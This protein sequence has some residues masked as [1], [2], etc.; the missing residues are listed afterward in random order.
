MTVQRTHR[1]R[2]L[3]L[4]AKGMVDQAQE[5]I[6]VDRLTRIGYFARGLIYGLMGFFAFQLVVGGHG[7]ITD[8]TGVLATLASQP[9]GKFLLIIVAIGM[10]GLFIWGLI[11]AIA[12]PFHK[13]SDFKGIIARTGYAISGI[14][15]GALLVP[16]LNLIQG[17]GKQAASS[18]Q[19]AQKAA[20]NILT[21]PG[22]QL[23]VELIGAV[24]I[25]VGIFRI[26]AGYSSRLN[27]SLKSYQMTDLE[28][29]W[30]MRLGRLGY[31]A[32]GIV[33]I[34]LG[35][36]AILGAATMD[37]NK[38]GGFDKALTFVVQQPYGPLLLLVIAVGLIAFAIY[39]IMG[40]L[41]F[42]IK[43]L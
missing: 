30:A 43:E 13:G 6:W 23:L 12:D 20:A 8:Q 27:E 37:P 21:R 36:L 5:N 35:F 15:Y 38:I 29:R 9:L 32:I 40:S 3:I 10:V 16:T 19:S 7:K 33:F 14:T 4:D 2:G 22:G 34:I 11:R 42:R 28:R 25:G 26:Y 41:W 1:P 39:S 31:V 24:L 18:T 17:T